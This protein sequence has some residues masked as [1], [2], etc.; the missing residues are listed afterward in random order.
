MQP[1]LVLRS[2]VIGAFQQTLSILRQIH[3]TMTITKQIFGLRM[4]DNEL[5]FFRN[6]EPTYTRCV[7][8]VSYLI[9]DQN[10]KF[11]KF[12]FF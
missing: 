3:F 11:K 1:G 12:S 5:I 9:S 6:R 8:P 7:V 4:A 10:R 2:G